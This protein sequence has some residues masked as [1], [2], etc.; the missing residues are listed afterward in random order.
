M[1]QICIIF[2][3]EVESTMIHLFGIQSR[4][5]YQA[6]FVLAFSQNVRISARNDVRFFNPVRV[7]TCYYLLFRKFRPNPI[8]FYRRK[9]PSNQG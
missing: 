2:S 5:K 9:D 1:V 6:T 3:V 4:A 8:D 7:G